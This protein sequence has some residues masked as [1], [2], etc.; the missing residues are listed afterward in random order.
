MEV[1][2]LAQEYEQWD[3]FYSASIKHIET[4]SQCVNMKSQ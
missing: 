2:W 3:L 1:E 4:I